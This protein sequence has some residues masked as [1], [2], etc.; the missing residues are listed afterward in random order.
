MNAAAGAPHGWGRGWLALAALLLPLF[1]LAGCRPVALRTPPQEAQPLTATAAGA[2][3]RVAVTDTGAGVLVTIHSATG[4]G[5]ATLTWPA[6]APPAAL[7]LRLHLAGMEE[8]TLA[9]ETATLTIHVLSRPPYTV[10]QS[11]APP[12]QP[13]APITPAS[14][15]WANVSSAPAG[16]ALPLTG[17]YFAVETP[18]QLLAD[19]AGQLTVRWIDFYR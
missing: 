2:G 12:G 5:R 16:A 10:A 13:L 14:P 19:A 15:Y 9:A 1:C 17:G 11:A 18:Q 7:T 4:I 3:D 8:L 6:D